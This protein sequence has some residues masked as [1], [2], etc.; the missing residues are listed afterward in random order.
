M[1]ITED[2]DYIMAI[3]GS[4]SG[5]YITTKKEIPSIKIPLFAPIKVTDVLNDYSSVNYEL[6]IKK[7]FT[8]K[9]GSSKK[10]LVY[11]HIS[12]ERAIAEL[13]ILGITDLDGNFQDTVPKP[14]FYYGLN[15]YRCK[16]SQC[17]WSSE[18]DKGMSGPEKD[19]INHWRKEHA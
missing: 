15:H 19:Y 16:C 7:K 18:S 9:T 3:G 8:D 5:T 11:E 13:Y 4:K 6:Y 1:S 14:K 2:Y 12:D 10:F 17:S